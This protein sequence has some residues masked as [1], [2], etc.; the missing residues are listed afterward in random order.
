MIIQPIVEGHGEVGAVPELLRR[1]IAKSG[2]P[3]IEVAKPIRAHRGDL[4]CEERLSRRLQVARAKR[5]DGIL[6]MLDG[7]DDCPAT[8]A[9]QIRDW[10]TASANPIPCEVVIAHREYEAWFLGAI[11]SL[12]GMRGVSHDAVSELQPE[13]F[14]DAK[15]RLESKM[16]SGQYVE[17]A[18]QVALTSSFDMGAAYRSCRSF[19]RFVRAFEILATGGGAMLTDW[20]PHW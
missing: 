19:R 13:A 1:L 10:A 6:I 15:G 12:R 11:E 3:A 18:D 8:L 7:D 9:G 16:V 2:N 5:P 4:I 14:R 17:T 20:P